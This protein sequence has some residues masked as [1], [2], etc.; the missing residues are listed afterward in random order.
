MKEEKQ[1]HIDIVENEDV[2][3]GGYHSAKITKGDKA[4]LWITLA[5]IAVGIGLII[6]S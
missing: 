2:N 5:L 1:N 3:G 4:V 6:I